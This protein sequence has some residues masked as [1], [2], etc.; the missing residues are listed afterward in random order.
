MKGPLGGPLEDHLGGPLGGPLENHP[1]GPLGGPLRGLL[2][3]QEAII[4][5][6][7][8]EGCILHLNKAAAPVHCCCCCCC[9]C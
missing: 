7:Y 6:E 8:L 2:T 9:C 4:T 5:L 3:R 1:G